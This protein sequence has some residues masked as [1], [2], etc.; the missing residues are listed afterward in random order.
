MADFPDCNYP[1]SLDSGPPPIVGSVAARDFSLKVIGEYLYVAATV[2]GDI[3]AVGGG[4]VKNVHVEQT[5][6]VDHP[7]KYAD[8]LFRSLTEG[9][10]AKPYG[11]AGNQ[12]PGKQVILKDGS[13]V[14]IRRAADGTLKVDVNSGSGYVK[15][16]IKPK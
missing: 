7:E 4:P 5:L 11:G 10:D 13:V 12:Y 6:E 15:F 2:G 16:T 1:G 3:V 14:G 9:M 8:D